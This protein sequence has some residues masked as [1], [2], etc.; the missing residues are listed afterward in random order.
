[1]SSFS[2]CAT[3]IPRTV[4]LLATSI[5]MLLM[6]GDAW[7]GAAS[8]QGRV[9]IRAQV[10]RDE[11]YVGESIR[12]QI[13]VE[14]A[15]GASN[16]SLDGIEEDF[17]IAFLGEHP[18]Q[19]SSTSFVN[20]RMMSRTLYRNTLEYTLTAKKIGEFEIPVL[21][22]EFQG[23][24]YETSP[25]SVKVI[26]PEAQDIVLV[27]V[28]SSAPYVYPTQW[29]DV[30]LVIL[31]KTVPGLSRDPVRMLARNPPEISL[32]WIQI[33][34]GLES[35]DSSE[36]LQQ[37]I[38]D[39]GTGFS[40]NGISTAG[41]FLFDSPRLALFQLYDGQETRAD[42][43]GEEV[44]YDRY[45]ISRRMKAIRPGKYSFGPV[46]VKGTFPVRY[47][48]EQPQSAARWEIQL[49]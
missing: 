48:G 21:K 11:V 13:H 38:S 8:G 15:Q 6:M 40:I 16:P 45:L 49:H 27:E 25:I 42:S 9:S 1:M 17:D 37:Y 20:G 14:N 22:L 29:F 18:M 4:W 41:A 28:R 30:S 46:M 24:V 12:F 34:D 35:Q 32:P 19:Q 43:S 3:S 23:E 26:E 7:I 39:S 2:F 10:D 5:A 36:W 47:E 33:P 31:V 44:T